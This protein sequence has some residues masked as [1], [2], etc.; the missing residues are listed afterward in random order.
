MFADDVILYIGNP[1]DSNKNKKRIVRII[2]KFNKVEGCK[3]SIQKSVSFIYTMKYLKEIKNPIHSNIKN[4]ELIR[5]NLTKK[6]KDPYTET[7]RH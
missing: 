3:I 2:D 1:K 4:N 5:I 6:M 7:E